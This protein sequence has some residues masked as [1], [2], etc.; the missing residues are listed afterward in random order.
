MM[1]C[2]L[3]PESLKGLPNA[4][5]WLNYFDR[6]VG[7][8]RFAERKGGGSVLYLTI[9]ESTVKAGEG[10][11]RPGLHIEAP[12][13]LVR[14]GLCVISPDF[15]LSRGMGGR[16]LTFES[17]MDGGLFMASDVKDSCRVWHCRIGRPELVIG[18][19]G[20][21][22]HMRAALNRKARSSLMGDNEVWWISDATPHES[23]PVKKGTKRTFVRLVSSEVSAW[24]ARHNTPNPHT[25][26]PATVLVVEGDKFAPPAE[27][28]SGQCGFC[29]AVLP[30]MYKC[31]VCDK[32]YCN[33]AHLQSDITCP[34][35]KDK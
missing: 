21:I 31:A 30:Q 11:R 18:E 28:M 20:S 27:F 32:L 12:G 29:N 3:S 25:P 8:F 22:E 16:T 5:M 33:A 19:G 9:H 4:A 2:H 23:L 24:Y 1:P 7:P 6:R 17:A 34:S 14:P 10:Q 35:K 13:T 15:V 26:L